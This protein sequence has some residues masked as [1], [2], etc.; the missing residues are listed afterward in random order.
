[1]EMKLLCEK[2]CII[3]EGPVW[4]ER[5]K[6]LYFVNGYENEVCTVDIETKELTVIKLPD[7]QTGVAAVA[8]G[9]NGDIILS[10]A[11]GVFILRDNKYIPLY[12]TEKHKI[13]YCNDMKVGPDGRLYVGTLSE[14]KRGI[15]DKIDG[16]LYSIDTSGNVKELLDKIIVSNGMAWSGD[17]KYFYHTDSDTHVIKEYTLDHESADISFTGR[18]VYVLG[19]DGFTIDKDDRLFVAC[20][21]Q[22]HVAVVDTKTMKITGYIKAPAKIPASCTFAGEDMNKLV[23]V[24]ATYGI[25]EY[26]W[27]ND[28]MVFIHDTDTKGRL[29]YELDTG[30]YTF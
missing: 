3:G 27:K 16:K 2:R 18:E 8:F 10:R 17:G 5:Q 9:K 22:G 25:P 14:K 20:W 11:D 6:L 15:S 1:M 26:D 13:L 23:V 7:P 4:N 30:K 12:D 29:P 24:T 19:V 21:D 28:G